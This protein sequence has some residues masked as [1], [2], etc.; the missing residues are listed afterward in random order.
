M[1]QK[2]YLTKKIVFIRE[3]NNE[4]KIFF[5]YYS[6]QTHI[7]KT[8]TSYLKFSTKNQWSCW[9]IQQFI[10]STRFEPFTSVAVSPFVPFRNMRPKS[11]QSSVSSTSKIFKSMFTK[12]VKNFGW[13]G[14]TVFHQKL[15]HLF[16]RCLFHQHLTSSFFVQKCEAQLL[17]TYLQLVFVFF[18]WKEIVEK[19]ALKILAQLASSVFRPTFNMH[20]LPKYSKLTCI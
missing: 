7:Y 17:C 4:L 6:L 18:S 12:R 11:E 20:F 9:A 13:L 19:G 8:P 16:F 1:P 5:F 14:P 3:I 10:G 2:Y 15:E